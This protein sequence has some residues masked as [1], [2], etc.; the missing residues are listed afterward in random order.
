M[1]GWLT[2]CKDTVQSC[3]VWR[4]PA[5][6]D[7]ERNAESGVSA[8]TKKHHRLPDSGP[9]RPPAF[10]EEP[11]RSWKGLGF[12]VVPDDR[13]HDPHYCDDKN[14]STNGRCTR[15]RDS[16]NPCNFTGVDLL[17]MCADPV[18]NRGRE[19][20]TLSST[21]NPQ[22]V[23]MGLKEVRT[24]GYEYRIAT[25]ADGGSAA[26]PHEDPPQGIDTISILRVHK[27]GLTESFLRTEFC[28][29]PGFVKL[30]IDQTACFIKFDSTIHAA[31]ALQAANSLSLGAAW[32]RQNL[33]DD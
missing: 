28:H 8:E 16:S 29:M 1:P 19:V 5:S 6:D 18:P 23:S 17:E 20:V 31:E 15:P 24:K 2:P 4:V 33:D 13:Q 27:K 25:V 32:A 9:H 10:I 26:A 12:E 30:Q 3:K 14:E 11:K 7:E 22:G 21:E